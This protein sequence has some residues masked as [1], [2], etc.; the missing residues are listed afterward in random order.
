MAAARRPRVLVVLKKSAYQIYVR[1]RGEAHIGRLVREK[2]PS[3]IHLAAGDRDH[4]RCTR[5]VTRA[6][7]RLE[8]D[9]E[10]HYRAER[11]RTSGLDLVVAVGGDG[12][13]LEASHHVTDVPVLSVNSSPKTSVGYFAGATSDDV[14]ERL[15]DILS[16]RADPVPLARMRVLRN[17]SPIVPLVTN[18]VLFCNDNPAATSRYI[19][20]VGPRSEHQKSSGIWVSTAAGSTAALRSAGGTVLAPRSRRIAYVVREPYADPGSR[21]EL[22]R[23]SVAAGERL[24]ITTKMRRSELYVDGSH[25]RHTLVI[26]ETV[27]FEDS[28]TPLRLYGFRRPA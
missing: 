25:L 13:L 22:R 28:G 21:V 10:L 5:V 15:R 27:T 4:A 16:G 9:F 7:R 23:G 6:L 3:V 12:T 26:G 24:A 2:H 8:V 14:E 18:D 11:F 19:L 20:E 17:G 1:E